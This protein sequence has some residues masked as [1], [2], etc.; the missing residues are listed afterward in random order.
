MT[1]NTTKTAILTQDLA[2]LVLSMNFKVVTHV[3]I[4][5]AAL[6][7][8]F[9]HSPAAALI[10]KRKPCSARTGL[11]AGSQIFFYIERFGEGEAM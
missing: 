5:E 1:I 8:S 3:T 10:P 4:R 9:F 2:R 7:T 6:F 11:K